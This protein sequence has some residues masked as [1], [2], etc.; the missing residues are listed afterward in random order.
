MQSFNFQKT[1][2][3]KR[4]RLLLEKKLNIKISIKG[5]KVTITSK[6][7]LNEYEASIILDAINFGFS[8][9][10][11]TPNKRARNDLQKNQYQRIY[12][13]KKF[14]RSE[15]KNHRASWK[16]KKNN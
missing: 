5:R 2:E 15:S 14:K 10:K 7:S 6:N 4:T 16:N 13:E 1:S 3:I 11:S 9:K 12:K 8:A